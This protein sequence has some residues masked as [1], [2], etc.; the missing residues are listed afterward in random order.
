MTVFSLRS[1]KSALS[2]MSMTAFLTACG[3]TDF[4]GESDEGPPLP[5]E[6][7]SILAVDRGVRP[8]P[9]LTDVA[10]Q[11]PKPY[12]NS[13][14]SQ[15]GGTSTH[16]MYHLELAD[17]PDVA[18]T[19]D[20]GDGSDD[21][22]RILTQPVVVDGVV[23]TMDAF[24]LVSAFDAATGRSI[25]SVD[26][27]EGEE[28]EGFFGGGVSFEDGRLFVSTGF[29]KIFSLDAKTGEELWER[30]VPGPMRNGPAVHNGRVY[31]LSVDNQVQA[32]GAEDGRLLWNNV[33]VEE[34]ANVLGAASPAANDVAVL[35]PYSTG[36]L[37]AIEAESGRVV[38]SENLAALTR[39]DP[40]ADIPQIRGL[41]VIDRDAVFAISHSG[42]ML[43]V[44]LRRGV[45]LWEVDLGGVETPWVGGEFL[46]TLTSDSPLVAVRR[47][48]GRIKWVT[49]L[50]RFEDEEDEEGLIQWMGPVLAG[51]RLIVAGTNGEALS[52]SPYDGELLGFIE[53]PGPIAVPPVVADGTLYLVTA[54]AELLAL[55]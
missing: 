43:A 45:R 50:P 3:L 14:W 22:A 1:I 32:L 16:A 17:A 44:E 35:V 55:R 25:W 46:F 18:W 27:A 26:L 38:W 21:D 7:I 41:P 52:I 13:D 29:A 10:V 31:A 9:E 42:R 53:L 2:L 23:Y 24:G 4:L 37:L 12:R 20:I 40:L 49:L 11:L 39:L 28:D 15:P 34:V 8:D 33:G 6:R 30:R 5:G 19:V 51:D 54:G 48:D 47:K 36:E